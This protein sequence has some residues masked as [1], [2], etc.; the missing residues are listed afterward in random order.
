MLP[1]KKRAKR[2]ISF[3]QFSNGI[4]R[5][6]SAYYWRNGKHVSANANGIPSRA[7]YRLGGN[8]GG[9]VLRCVA[10]MLIVVFIKLG[11]GGDGNAKPAVNILL[12]ATAAPILISKPQYGWH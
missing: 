4:A 5:V 2:R 7:G 1:T 10:G 9:L 8:L 11:S 3:Q 12:A 6:A